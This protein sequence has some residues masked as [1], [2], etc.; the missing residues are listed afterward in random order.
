MGTIGH[1][2]ADHSCVFLL[3][4]SDLNSNVNFLFFTMVLSWSEPAEQNLWIMG[5]V[6]QCQRSSTVVI[7]LGW[8][9]CRG[10]ARGV[11]SSEIE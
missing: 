3:L 2:K 7:V 4:K 1:G 10:H 5:T 6:G 9:E 8:K 11:H